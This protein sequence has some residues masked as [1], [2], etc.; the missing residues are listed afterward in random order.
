MTIPSILKIIAVIA[1]PSFGSLSQ[2]K[3]N[4]LALK[5]QRNLK[6]EGG[7]THRLNFRCSLGS[8]LSSPRETLREESPNPSEWWKSSL[9]NP[10][11]GE[12]NSCGRKTKVDLKK[13][14][15]LGICKIKVSMIL[16]TKTER[17]N[18]L[19]TAS[20]Y[21]SETYIYFRNF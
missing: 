12:N 9:D 6:R 18:S 3:T 2:S 20:N 8:G 14:Q 1:M 19:P 17:A 7:T 4:T 15:W 13:G 16:Y 11:P 5:K 10:A 21:C